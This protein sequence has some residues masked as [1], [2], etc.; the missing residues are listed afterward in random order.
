MT[1]LPEGEGKGQLVRDP[2][3]VHL[4]RV[5]DRLDADLGPV[6]RMPVSAD[7]ADLLLDYKDGCGA[8]RPAVGLV[9]SEGFGVRPGQLIDVVGLEDAEA[10]NAG[11]GLDDDWEP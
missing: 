8:V 1:D 7:S 11:G 5:D 4:T 9:A 2:Q 3:M 6:S 10:P